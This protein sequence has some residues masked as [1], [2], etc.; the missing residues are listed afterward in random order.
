MHSKLLARN[1]HNVVRLILP[2]EPVGGDR[3]QEAGQ[4]FR[5]WL[6][7]GILNV[8][9]SPALFMWEQEFSLDGITR[10]RR[11]LV[12]KVTCESYSPGA[13]MRHEYTHDSPKVDRLKLFQATGA[14]FS[15][16]FGIFE[17]DNGLATCLAETGQKEPLQTARGD[18]GHISRLFRIDS[19]ETIRE[20]QAHLRECT[21]T[22]ADGHHRYESS[23]AYYQ[24]LGRVGSTLMTLVPSSDPGLV[25]LPTHRTVDLQVDDQTFSRTLSEKYTITIYPMNDWQ[26]CYEEANGNPDRRIILA[27]APPADK[28]F[29]IE[30]RGGENPLK[31]SGDLSQDLG[32]VT[33][34]HENILPRLKVTERKDTATFGYFHSAVDAVESAR[35]DGRWAF[36]VRPTSVDALIRAT[37]YQEVMPPKSTYFFPKFLSGFV[38]ARLD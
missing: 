8:H 35:A 36:L 9:E 33:E 25:V 2:E 20:F 32:D 3:Y 26:R 27:V 7:A 34:L 15:Q 13:V 12:A 30:K 29:F 10:T 14:Q 18:D 37:K 31:T 6:Q 5:E 19:K 23:V 1:P 16:I 21:I 4:Q 17:D 38:N 11:A 24:K 22:I 28:T